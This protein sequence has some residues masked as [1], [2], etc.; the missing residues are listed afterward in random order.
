MVWYALPAFNKGNVAFK[1][2]RSI[3]HMAIW[4]I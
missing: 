4:I 1:Y 3:L 2:M